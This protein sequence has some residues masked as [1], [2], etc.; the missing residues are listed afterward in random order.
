M[1]LVV[2]GSTWLFFFILLILGS[3]GALQRGISD[4]PHPVYTPRFV[5]CANCHAIDA[6]RAMPDNHRTFGQET[7]LLCHLYP[8]PEQGQEVVQASSV[9]WLS[10]SLHIRNQCQA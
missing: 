5:N 8:G 3:A 6:R 10:G 9:A 7:C 4:A 1:R 2:R